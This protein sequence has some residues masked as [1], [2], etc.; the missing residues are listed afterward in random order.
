MSISLNQATEEGNRARLFGFDRLFLDA[1]QKHGVP[2][3]ILAAVASRETNMGQTVTADWTG[4]G[5]HGR[6]LMQID[7]RWHTA[8]VDS[9]ANND[10]A[11]NIDYAAGLLATEHRHFGEWAPALAAYNAGR[12]RV[13]TAIG[14]GQSPDVPTTGGNYSADVLARAQLFEVVF[15][16]PPDPL[17]N[18][19]ADLSRPLFELGSSLTGRVGFR[20]NSGGVY[21]PPG[22]PSVGDGDETRVG[23]RNAD[24]STY[25]PPS[26]RVSGGLFSTPIVQGG[27]SWGSVAIAAAVGVGISIVANR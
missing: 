11:A 13:S 5:G 17:G 20:T 2:F 21:V 4:D 10:H 6:G 3:S 25:I 24:G 7:D 22:F 26:A 14:A 8:F 18:L 23:F 19:F 1:E 15:P 12:S 9:T 16:P 27:P